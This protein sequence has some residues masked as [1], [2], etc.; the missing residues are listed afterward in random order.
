MIIHIDI[1]DV[2]F[3]F[4]P[5]FKS[6][7]EKSEDRELEMP[8]QWNLA[9]AW[10]LTTERFNELYSLF[11]SYGFL[12]TKESIADSVRV[13]NDLYKK[14]RVVLVTSRGTVID[15]SLIRLYSIKDTAT[16]LRDMNISY[17]SLHFTNKK[18][19]KGDY[20]IDDGVHNLI[21]TECNPICFDQ[22]WNQEY[23]GL[24]VNNWLELEKVF[25]NES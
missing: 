21:A 6:F 14:H 1:D 15:D 13:M 19:L 9:Q 25:D 2:I 24:R 23:D 3:P 16:W 8:K 18:D 12:K 22:P 11:V 20:L 17:H 10:D 7:C 5:L 4:I